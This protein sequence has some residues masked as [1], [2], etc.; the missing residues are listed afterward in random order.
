MFSEKQNKKQRVYCTQYVG[1]VQDAEDMP[2]PKQTKLC[3]K[4]PLQWI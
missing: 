4:F 1:T 3:L 2:R